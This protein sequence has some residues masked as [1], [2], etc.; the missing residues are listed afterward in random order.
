MPKT[1]LFLGFFVG[2]GAGLLKLILRKQPQL[3]PATTELQ[4]IIKPE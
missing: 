4:S 2:D 1:T 3:E